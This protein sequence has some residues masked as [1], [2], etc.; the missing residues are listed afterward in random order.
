MDGS[1]ETNSE[2]NHGAPVG[3]AM[4]IVAYCSAGL[5]ACF[6]VVVGLQ[7]WTDNDIGSVV[8]IG[9]RVVWVFLILPFILAYTAVP[10]SFAIWHAGHRGIRSLRYYVL[11]GIGLGLLW[12]LF[13]GLILPGLY[14]DVSGWL[15][16]LT[17]LVLGG[18]VAGLVFWGVAGRNV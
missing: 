6:V 11:A 4:I 9:S 16:A 13:P 15:F 2:R 8:V 10:A 1:P 17:V 18:M 14:G 7:F 12:F 3:C 5:A